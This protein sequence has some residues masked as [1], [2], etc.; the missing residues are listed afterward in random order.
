MQRGIRPVIDAE[1]ADRDPHASG[2]RMQGQRE[3]LFRAVVVDL[4]DAVEVIADA[5]EAQEGHRVR[6]ER[7]VAEEGDEVVVGIVPMSIEIVIRGGRNLEPFLVNLDAVHAHRR[8]EERVVLFLVGCRCIRVFHRHVAEAVRL[9]HLHGSGEVAGA[10]RHRDHVHA[11]RVELAVTHDGKK[12]AV[13]VIPVAFE[14]IQ[15]RICLHL[16][17]RQKKRTREKSRGKDFFHVFLPPK[18][19]IDTIANVFIL[20]QGLNSCFSGEHA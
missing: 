15:F 17:R 16:R 2:R 13:V 4:E 1:S 20:H 11:E 9:L 3:I 18:C 14:Q 8:A 12:F 10:A 19:K 5:V 7:A 6:V